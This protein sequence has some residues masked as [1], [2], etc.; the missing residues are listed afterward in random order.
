MDLF[1]MVE[2]LEMENDEPDLA[3]RCGD[4]R[5]FIYEIANEILGGMEY[6]DII[7]L[8]STIKDAEL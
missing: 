5:E 7:E 8:A 2:K 3:L 1:K 4:L 6:P